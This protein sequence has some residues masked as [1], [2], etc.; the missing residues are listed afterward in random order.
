MTQPGDRELL[1]RHEIQKNPPD[2]L[3]TNYS[4]L[5][6]MLLRPIERSIFRKTSDWLA[7]DPRNQFLLVLDEAHMYRGV[8]G[9]EVGLLI[10]RLQSRLELPRPNAMHPDQCESGRRR[11]GRGGGKAVWRGAD[12]QAQ[13]RWL[14]RH[15]RHKRSETE[16]LPLERPLR[17]LRLPPSIPLYSLASTRGYRAGTCLGC[18][19][20]WLGSARWRTEQ[21]V[22]KQLTG[23]GPLELLIEICAG[24]GTAFESL[25]HQRFPTVPREEAEA[26]T[27]GL[28]ASG[29]FARRHESG[30]QEQPLLPTRVRM[31]FRGLPSVHAC[32]NEECKL[33]RY[34]AVQSRFWDVSTRSLGPTAHVVP[35][36]SGY[37]LI[38]IAARP[39]MRIFGV[40]RRADFLWNEHGGTISQFG[41]PL[42]EIHF[43]L[44]EPHPDQ[45][46]SVEPVWL[47]I[48]TGR[49]QERQPSEPAGF[50]LVYRPIEADEDEGLSTIHELSGLHTPNEH[51]RVAQDHGSGDEG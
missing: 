3:V 45:V 8:S 42:H 34:S 15:S 46:R 2:L 19:I 48:A 29:S 4:M 14:Y 33:R 9:A 7:G 27:D 28:L 35:A 49:F 1:T 31:F 21:Y 16:S 5:E 23:T 47:D 10:R 22:G 41:A 39:L 43:L 37:S 11:N 6:Y 51:W 12:R 40:G 25:A 18:S 50:R 17:Q 26:A 36:S 30:R 44:E 32:L 24:N 38:G 13:E 20:T